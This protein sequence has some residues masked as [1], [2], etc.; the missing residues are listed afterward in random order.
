VLV[1]RENIDE[2]LGKTIADAV[3]SKS[4]DASDIRQCVQVARLCSGDVERAKEILKI[5]K[6]Q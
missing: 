1:I 4:Q 2:E 3:W 6:R 5:L